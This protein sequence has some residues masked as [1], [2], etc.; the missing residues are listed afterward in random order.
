MRTEDLQETD[1]SGCTSSSCNM[2]NISLDPEQMDNPVALTED[3][4]G[5][6]ALGS[7]SNVP[8][9]SLDPPAASETPMILISERKEKCRN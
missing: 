7:Q 3:S 9:D 6:Q 4:V 1:S 5:E 8:N 2:E